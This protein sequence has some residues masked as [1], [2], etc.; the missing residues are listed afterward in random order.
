[1]FTDTWVPDWIANGVD[2]DTCEI[3]LPENIF[4]GG[5]G[6]FFEKAPDLET[7]IEHHMPDY[8]LYDEWIASEV[9]RARIEKEKNGKQ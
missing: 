6:F 9:E 5:T 7:E 4:V 8:H 3:N 1:M 2:M